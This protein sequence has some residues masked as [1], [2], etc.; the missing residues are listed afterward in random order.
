MEKF[1]ILDQ[2][3]KELG[4][5]PQQVVER[6]IE[7][8]TINPFDLPVFINGTRVH[9]KPAQICEAK[10]YFQD[11][12]KQRLFAT[13]SLIIAKTLN[14]NANTIQPASNFLMDLGADSLGMIELWQNIEK[15]FN[16]SIT[17]QDEDMKTVQDVLDY[18]SARG[19]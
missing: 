18:L 5:T 3:I 4:L 17:D 10:V 14:I 13:L 2:H 1:R 11:E 12:N 7:N 6:W 8:E 15:E 9:D 16:C 19:K